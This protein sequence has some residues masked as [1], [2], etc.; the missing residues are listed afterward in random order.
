MIFY[1][2]LGF[3]FG[4]LVALMNFDSK[5]SIFVNLNAQIIKRPL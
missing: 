3:V 1:P 5:L 4:S 2:I